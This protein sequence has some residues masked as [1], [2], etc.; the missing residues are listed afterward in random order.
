MVIEWLRARAPGFGALSAQEQTAIVGFTLLWSLFEARVLNGHGNAH[1]IRKAIRAWD[2]N[3]V[4]H[5]DSYAEALTYFRN[6][7]VADGAFTPHYQHLNLRD[8]DKPA[9]VATVLQGRNNNAVDGVAVVFIIIYRYRNNLLHGDKWRYLLEG[10]LGNFTTSNRVLMRA[11]E[12]H[13]R[14][15]PG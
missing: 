3:G 7:Y 13:G 14:L 4:L 8:N 9:L 15:P 6:R 11:L 12:D 1:S 10:Q 5:A 2:A